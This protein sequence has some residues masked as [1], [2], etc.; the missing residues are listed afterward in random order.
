MRL[1]KEEDVKI[2]VDLKKLEGKFPKLFTRKGKFK[3]V[4]VKANFK[5][6]IM[7]TKHK[8]RKIPA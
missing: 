1:E 7:R 2:P 5:R 6:D 3:R 8:G 4:K